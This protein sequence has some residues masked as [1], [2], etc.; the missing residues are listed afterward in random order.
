MY[1]HAKV[2]TETKILTKCQYLHTSLVYQKALKWNLS[3]AL[4]CEVKVEGVE[5]LLTG[6]KMLWNY[7]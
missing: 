4:Y 3:A 6:D 1:K 7:R 2:T 5:G